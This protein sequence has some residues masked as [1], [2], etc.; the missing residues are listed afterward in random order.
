MHH[1]RCAMLKV[2]HRTP[3]KPQLKQ[4]PRRRG[5]AMT[6]ISS[7]TPG[8]GDMLDKTKERK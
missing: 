5:P 6:A 1:E 2:T 3:N 4:Y 8:R 7:G